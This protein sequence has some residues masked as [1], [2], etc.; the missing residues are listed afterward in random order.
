MM[1]KGFSCLTAAALALILFTSPAAQ[2]LTVEQAAD[3]LELIY[4]DE[5]PQAVLEQP[6]IQDMLDALG[7]LHHVG[8]LPGGHRRR[9]SPD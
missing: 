2:A 8:Y 6:T 1:K 5:V 4:V 9:I 3:L 7:D